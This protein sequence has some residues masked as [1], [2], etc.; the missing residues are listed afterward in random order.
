MKLKAHIK[1]EMKELA[2]ERLQLALEA[3]GTPSSENGLDPLKEAVCAEIKATQSQVNNPDHLPFPLT[4]P[5]ST[6]YALIKGNSPEE[7]HQRLKEVITLLRY[8]QRPYRAELNPEVFKIIE[9]IIKT[10][11]DSS[12]ECLNPHDLGLV[13]E[14]GNI[15]GQLASGN[16]TLPI[17][18]ENFPHYKLALLHQP[19]KEAP[20]VKENY[21]RLYALLEEGQIPLMPWDTEEGQEF[22]LYS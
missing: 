6:Y 8:G 18:A 21:S 9:Y 2:I 7:E 11:K 22:S 10:F 19:R 20:L 1:K 17:N 13:E 15:L 14:L 5:T 12:P 4:L 3:L 16:M